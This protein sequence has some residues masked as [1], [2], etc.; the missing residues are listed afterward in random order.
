LPFIEP[1][2]FAYSFFIGMG[3]SW[4]YEVFRPA[5][6]TTER[7]IVSM[8]LQIGT[9]SLWLAPLGMAIYF[10]LWVLCSWWREQHRRSHAYG[11]VI[12]AEFILP[13]ARHTDHERLLRFPR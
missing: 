10:M 8:T 12:R 6:R 9:E 2:R 5:C 7:G 13:N 11:R 4:I 1:L 3:A